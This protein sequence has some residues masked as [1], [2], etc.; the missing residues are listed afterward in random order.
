V[1]VTVIVTTQVLKQT[2]PSESGP[3]TPGTG[4]AAPPTS[5][6]DP[7]SSVPRAGADLGG[8]DVASFSEKVGADPFVIAFPKFFSVRGVKTLSD[9][10]CFKFAGPEKS[11]FVWVVGSMT[12]AVTTRDLLHEV[13]LDTNERTPA[14]PASQRLG[15]VVGSGERF[16][17]TLDPDPLDAIVLRAPFGSGN[18]REVVALGAAPQHSSRL[19]SVVETLFGSLRAEKVQG[20]R[21]VGGFTYLPR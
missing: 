4:P 20:T 19:R 2:A 9:G 12:G 7:F 8:D 6:G 18:E 17:I 10:K 16:T 21:A 5:G 13:G 14:R 15:P 3:S 1:I 11:A